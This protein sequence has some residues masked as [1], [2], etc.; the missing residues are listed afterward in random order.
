MSELERA[1]AAGRR[2]SGGA[3]WAGA[4]LVLLGLAFLAQNTGLLPRTGNWWAYFIL[5]PSLALLGRA[6]QQNVAGGSGEPATGP[7]TGGLVLLVVALIFLFDLRWAV[8]WPAI[9]IVIGVG[10]LLPSL[11]RR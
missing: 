4:A 6:W 7:L 5:I 11:T 10:L 8:A 3:L 1:P 2:E 9:P